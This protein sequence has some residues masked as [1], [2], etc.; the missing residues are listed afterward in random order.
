MLKYDVSCFWKAEQ[1]KK[2]SIVL[3]DSRGPHLLCLSATLLM[4]LIEKEEGCLRDLEWACRCSSVGLWLSRPLSFLL[5]QSPLARDRW[6]DWASG[7]PAASLPS[8]AL[9]LPFLGLLSLP[10]VSG[11]TSH[12]LHG[13]TLLRVLSMPLAGTIQL[14]LLG[15]MGL[16]HPLC[17]CYGTSK[18]P[19]TVPA[20]PPKPLGILSVSSPALGIRSSWSPPPGTRPN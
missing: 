16:L 14:P 3:A 20:P 4:L 18:P 10:R 2:F 7:F 11:S 13:I 8:R 12:G 19:L 6:P 15:T 1:R 9:S 17:R 5:L